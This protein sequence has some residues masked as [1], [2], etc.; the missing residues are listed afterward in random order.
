MF[1]NLWNQ[2]RLQKHQHPGPLPF[3]RV[4]QVKDLAR[5]LELDRIIH[6]LLLLVSFLS[7]QPVV[8]VLEVTVHSSQGREQK[9]EEIMRVQA[10]SVGQPQ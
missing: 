10:Q 3:S 9:L 7:S 2:P 4:L 8:S 6:T 1:L 5:A